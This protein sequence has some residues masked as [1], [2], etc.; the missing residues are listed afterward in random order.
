MIV[1]WRAK[2]SKFTDGA[3]DAEFPFGWVQINSDGGYGAGYR[4][5]S[6]PGGVL[7]PAKPP[8]NCGQGCS[9][10]WQVHFEQNYACLFGY[11]Q[12]SC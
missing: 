8:G 10:E 1:D 9:P 3:T 7:N 5:A 11:K 12:L 6:S 2:W 4:N